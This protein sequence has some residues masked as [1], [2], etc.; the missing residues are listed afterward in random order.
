[1]KIRELLYCAIDPR[2][3]MIS[4]VASMPNGMTSP[5]QT[6][7]PIPSSQGGVQMAQAPVPMLPDTLANRNTQAN[8]QADSIARGPFGS[9]SPLP[10]SSGNYFTDMVGRPPIPLK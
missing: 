10:T 3:P 8:S 1:M 9:P 4:P 5:S 2:P 6:M 7:G